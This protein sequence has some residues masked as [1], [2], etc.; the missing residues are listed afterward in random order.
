MIRTL[1]QIG[2]VDSAGSFMNNTDELKSVY[3]DN[4]IAYLKNYKFNLCPENSNNRH[5]VTEKIAHAIMAGC[6]PVYWG[7][8]G[9]PEREIFN[10]EAIIIWR[11]ESPP[12]DQI[13]ELYES[14]SKYRKFFEQPRLL[15]GAEDQIVR[16]FRELEKKLEAICWKNTRNPKY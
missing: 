3:N 6:I 5:Y 7:A 14:D 4:K 12:I 11:K 16:M 9:E 2:K 8:C 13:R 10:S 1:S 15:P